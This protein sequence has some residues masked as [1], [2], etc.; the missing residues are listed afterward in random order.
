M[1]ILIAEDDPYSRRLLQR[2]LEKW[3]HEVVAAKDGL[4]AWELFRKEPCS[5]VIS[6]WMMPGIDGLELI[7]RI[8]QHP[9]DGYIYTVLLTA[10]DRKEDL[11]LGMETGADEYLTKPFD[12]DELNVRLRAGE[13]IIN[14]EKNLADRNR[15]LEA[16]NQRM[17]KDLEIAAQIQASLLPRS[18]PEVEELAFGWVFRPCDELAGDIFNVFPLD[19]HHVAFYVLDVSGHGVP[20]ALLSVTL[21][22][23]LSPSEKDSGLLVRKNDQGERLIVS[24]AEVANQLNRRFPLEETTEQYFTILYGIVNI[25]SRKMRFVSAGHPEVLYLPAT[26][27]SQIIETSSMPIGFSEFFTYEERELQLAPGDRI[28]LYS[29]GIVEA[30]NPA[31]ELWGKERFLESLE[32]GKNLDIQKVVDNQID[33]ISDWTQ[34]EGFEDD[35]TLLGIEVR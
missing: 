4:E 31:G 26:G 28:F 35:V 34:R 3:G 8:R 13:R 7:R 33:K 30:R 10:K 32:T 19:E 6:D 14:L 9:T 22:R 18:K 5:L 23:L 27:L 20:A 2:R 12:A 21:S 15:K 1:K 29:D 16:I 17:K 11:I 24:P 25:Q